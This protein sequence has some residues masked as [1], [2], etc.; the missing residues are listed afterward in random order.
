MEPLWSRAVHALEDK[1]AA[2]VVVLDVSGVCSFTDHIIVSTGMSDRQIRAMAQHVIE[3]LGDPFGL[4]GMDR[5]RWVL[6][7]YV[8]VVIHILQEDLRTYYDIEGMWFDAK[9]IR[10]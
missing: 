1:K 8:D 9:R 5:G 6:L 7:D 2:D 10:G 3:T 4:E